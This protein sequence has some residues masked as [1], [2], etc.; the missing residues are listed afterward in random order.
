MEHVKLICIVKPINLTLIKK[1]L[2]IKT[3]TKTCRIWSNTSNLTC[4]VMPAERKRERRVWSTLCGVLCHRTPSLSLW[5]ETHG[6][7]FTHTSESRCRHSEYRELF[8]KK[9]F[10]VSVK[11]A[12]RRGC[13]HH[14]VLLWLSLALMDGVHL[15]RIT[16]VWTPSQFG[17]CT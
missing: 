15:K 1:N 5:K 3:D 17:G 13:L 6:S 7:A 10:A 9:S 4:V 16:S 12:Q 2:I 8:Q 14:Y 11:E